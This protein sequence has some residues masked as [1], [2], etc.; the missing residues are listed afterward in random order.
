MVFSW[1][2]V[3]P[4]SPSN[5]LSTSKKKNHKA[6][7]SAMC[8]AGLQ[9]PLVI[10]ALRAQDWCALLWHQQMELSMD[11]PSGRSSLACVGDGETPSSAGL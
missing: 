3:G 11:G 4:G 5:I 2:A 9:W 1:A 10:G 6:S 7:T 8:R